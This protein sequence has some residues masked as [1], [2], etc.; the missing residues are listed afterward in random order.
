MADRLLR[1]GFA[2]SDRVN[3]LSDWAHRVFSHLI[4]RADDTGRIDA[5]PEMAKSHLFPSGTTRRASDVSKAFQELVKRDLAILYEYAGKPYL[6]VMRW[7]CCGSAQTSKYPWKDGRYDVTYVDWYTTDGIKQFVSTSIPS[8]PQEPP[9]RP[10]ADPVATPT[11]G[12]IRKG[13]LGGLNA[14]LIS[15]TGRN[16]KKEE[17]KKLVVEIPLLLRTKEFVEIWEEWVSHRTQ[18]RHPL[19]S[20]TAER[21]LKML[22]ELG[23]DR[24][25]AALKHSITNGW[26]GIFEP[27]G[28]RRHE[29]TPEE[30]GRRIASAGKGSNGSEA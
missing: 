12:Q 22:A 26:Q 25:I 15:K 2:D 30:F 10:P 16:S 21:Q 29:E 23:I 28:N 8:G 24:A 9:P 27:S 17:L 13:G 11:T 7:R 19:K 1:E 4:V 18:I 6:Q 3:A 20:L 5:R 14:Y